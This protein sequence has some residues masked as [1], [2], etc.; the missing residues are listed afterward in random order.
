M[1]PENSMNV[2]ISGKPSE[3]NILGDQMADADS[4]K[5]SDLPM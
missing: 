2:G 5:Y 3:F 4:M 1:G